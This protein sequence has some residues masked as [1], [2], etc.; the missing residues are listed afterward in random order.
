MRTI[1]EILMRTIDVDFDVYKALTMRRTSEDVSENDVLRQLFG[2]STKKESFST[3]GS[4][5]P[6]DWVTKGIRFPAGTEFRANYKG[7]THLARVE[8]GALVLSGKRYDTP[9]AAAMSIT[10]SPVNGWTFWECRLPG[11]AGWKIIK[12]LRK[13]AA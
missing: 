6:G 3:V 12:A 1:T 5:G 4:A 7:Q 9:S 2:L 13:S 11:Q 10:A 8:G